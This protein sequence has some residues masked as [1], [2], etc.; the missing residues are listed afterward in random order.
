MVDD[1]TRWRADSLRRYATDLRTFPADAGS[2]WRAAGWQGVAEE[3]RR[4][5]LD[6][7]GGYTRKF[8]IETDLSRL[9]EVAPPDSVEIRIFTG[10]DWS[11]LG[12]MARSRTAGQ[13]GEATAAGRLCLVAWKRRQAV[14]YAW[15][16]HKI[17]TRHE[18]YDLPLPSD[19]IYIWQVQVS[20]GERRQGVAAAL[21][22]AGLQLARD[23][24]SRRSWMF[25]KPE[26]VA[27]LRTIASVAPS[28][29]LG[30]IARIKLLSWIRNPY[31]ALC[32]PVPIKT[33]AGRN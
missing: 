16:S 8:V 20:R 24:G 25:I 9:A 15:F 5:T 17:E 27:S 22:S 19:A 18:S 12:D 11:L 30:T 32:A 31:R 2:A 28:R 7:I 33:R 14:G 26:N 10:P 4:R 13:F 6:P 1:L 21:L 23:R 29:V 3:V